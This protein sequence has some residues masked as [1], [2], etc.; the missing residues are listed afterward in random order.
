M[1]EEKT[2]PIMM[3]IN[4]AGFEGKA[5]SVFGA[6]DP[7]NDVL[8][9]AKE[10]D[11]EQAERAGFLRIT[12]QQHDVHHDAVFGDDDMQA[13]IAAYFE[14]TSLD[15]LNI[16]AGA[17]QCQP[18][19][20]IERDGVDAGGMKYRLQPDMKNGQVAVLAACLYASKQRGMA[21]VNEFMDDLAMISI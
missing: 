21:A 17:Q 18:S 14:L 8:L 10:G 13:A 12:N 16:G 5:V 19:H 4:M 15:L 20:K 9:I 11:Y 3:R 6:F 2:K 7:S 1:S